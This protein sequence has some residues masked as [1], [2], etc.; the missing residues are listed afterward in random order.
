M[1]DGIIKNGLLNLDFGG[2]VI[3][4]YENKLNNL[5][6]SEGWRHL[7]SV[8]SKNKEVEE[9]EPK[10]K[11]EGFWYMDT[12]EDICKELHTAYGIS[13]HVA[14]RVGKSI[15]A[16]KQLSNLHFHIEIPKLKYLKKE[17]IFKN[18]SPT[19]I[20]IVENLYANI[21]HEF[22]HIYHKDLIHFSLS[23]K[24]SKE[25]MIKSLEI[26]KEIRADLTAEEKLLN[27]HKKMRMNWVKDN[28]TGLSR[29]DREEILESFNTYDTNVEAII[30]TYLPQSKSDLI[31]FVKKEFEG[32][33]LVYFCK[34]LGV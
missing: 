25:P 33:Q 18:F 34:L 7:K 27:M 23:E 16:Y 22:A 1:K 3:M 32:E 19:N 11:Y 14:V 20:Y 12:V 2:V 15:R 13:P 9:L 30:E 10:E 17:L 21:A 5:H 26:L 24:C 28:P 31:S 8:L 4:S 29:A 6:F